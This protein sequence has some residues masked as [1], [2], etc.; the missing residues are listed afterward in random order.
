MWNKDSVA[1]QL[2]KQGFQKVAVPEFRLFGTSANICTTFQKSIKAGERIT[3]G[4]W[5]VLIF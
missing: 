4:K 3:M 5:G 1:D 2:K